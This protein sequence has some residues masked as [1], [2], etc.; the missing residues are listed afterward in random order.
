MEMDKLI[1]G[2]SGQLREALEI[3]AS[4]NISKASREIK[5]ITVSGLGG[6]GIGGNIA[7]EFLASELKVPMNVNKGYFIPSYVD[8]HSLVIISSYSGNTEETLNAMS[9]AEEAGALI[10][11]VSSNGKVLERAKE[12][13]YEHIRVPGGLP[14]RACLGY[15][16]VQQL[17]I[18]HKMGF[19]SDKAIREVQKSAALLDGL[20]EEIRTDARQLAEYFYRHLPVLYICDRMA[21][22]AVRFRQQI[23]E[24]AKMLCWHHVI[25]E[26][27]H[28]ELVG[29]RD[30]NE[31]LAVL[32]IR[33][34]DDYPRNQQRIEL[35]KKIIA[36]Y[37][38]HV[39]ELWSKGETPVQKALYLIHLT[40][41]TS[42]Y[43]AEL[44]GVDPVEVNVIDYLKGEL[45]KMH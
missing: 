22:V 43:L 26:M 24:N 40:D 11:A 12:K 36:K 21:G 19:T 27:N 6:S 10:V 35:N 34:E 29:W 37:T 42:F 20:E 23:N 7:A 30:K 14:P 3:G 25:P 38:P 9:M 28:N 16:L 1:A 31:A 18:L 41:W 44:R 32:F 39:R 8:E 4:A 2:F 13:G 17:F 5:N 33:N 15:S 45:A